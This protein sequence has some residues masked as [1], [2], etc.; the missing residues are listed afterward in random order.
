MTDLSTLRAAVAGV[1]LTPGEAG[2]VDLVAPWLQ[3]A[4]ITPAVAVG[5]KT[6]S[7]VALAVKFA[8]AEGHPVRIQ[9]TGHGAHD[10][11]TSGVL[12]VTKGLDHLTIDAQSKSA[13]IGAG[14]P[15]G[16]VITAAAE[17]GLAPIAGSSGTVGVVGFLLGGGLGPLIRSHGFGSDYVRE[18]EV[19]TADGALVRASTTQH[20]ELFWALRGGKGGLGVVTEVTIALVDLPTL[21]G[22]TLMFDAPYIESA[23]RAWLAYTATADARVS[24]SAALMRFPDA[25][26]IPDRSSRAASDGMCTEGT[27]VC[28]EALLSCCASRWSFLRRARQH[29]AI[30]QA[31][32]V[33]P[34]LDARPRWLHPRF[35]TPRPT[36]P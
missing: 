33:Q 13:T 32:P 16:A 11:I 5:A 29:P 35:G 20:P 30:A 19:V 18:L 8:T 10:P 27:S 24:T 3:G 31:S 34:A 25:P 4:A 23:L 2:F 17:H 7:D 22:G 36:F 6:P 28:H 26:F 12:V 1:V 9:A 15:W 14:V 21:Y